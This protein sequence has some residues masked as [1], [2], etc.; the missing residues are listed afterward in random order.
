MSVK[1]FQLNPTQFCF[2]A[3]HYWTYVRRHTLNTSLYTHF[4]LVWLY[5][6]GVQS[7]LKFQPSYLLSSSNITCKNRNKKNAVQHLNY[8]T[9]MLLHYSHHLLFTWT[10]RVTDFNGISNFGPIST[11][12]WHWHTAKSNQVAQIDLFLHVFF[13]TSMSNTALQIYWINLLFD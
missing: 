12:S 8:Q 10:S 7:K 6:L 9:C 2:T 1:S 11:Q 4:R 13:Q 3:P 5:S